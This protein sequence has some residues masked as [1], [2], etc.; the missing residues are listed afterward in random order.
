M[1]AVERI[2]RE[3]A[4]ALTEAGIGDV[5]VDYID[6]AYVSALPDTAGQRDLKP[7][8]DWPADDSYPALIEEDELEDRSVTSESGERGTTETAENEQAITRHVRFV[9]RPAWSGGLWHFSWWRGGQCTS[10]RGAGV[11]S[12][13]SDTGVTCGDSDDR[14]YKILW[15]TK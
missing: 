15:Y 8:A 13:I 10:E 3:T 5:S 14:I 12:T 7:V 11:V 9:W 1:E 2:R 6:E 4:D